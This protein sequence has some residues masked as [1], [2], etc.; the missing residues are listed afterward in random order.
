MAAVTAWELYCLFTLPR[1]VHPTLSSLLD[2]LDARPAGKVVAFA[3]WLVLGW[4]VV[5][6]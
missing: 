3:V 5:A 4:L 2:M 1:R 6:A